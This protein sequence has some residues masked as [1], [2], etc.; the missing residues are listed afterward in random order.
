MATVGGNVCNASPSANMALPLILLGASAKIV[1]GAGERVIPFG[2][3]FKGANQTTLDPK[4]ILVEIQI[5]VMPPDSTATYLKLGIRNSPVERA[6]VAV[7]TF[8]ELDKEHKACKDARIVLGAVGP[9]PIIAS[10]AAGYLAGKELND[11]IIAAAANLASQEAKPITDI[12]ASAEYR[13]EMVKVLTQRA[14]KQSLEGL[15]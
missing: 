9:A 3:I 7:A 5:P 6:V 11:T 4:E 8:I 10:R 2:T 12:S 14:I 1:S 13:T 15:A